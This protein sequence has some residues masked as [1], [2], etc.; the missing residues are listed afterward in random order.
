MPLEI[1]SMSTRVGDSLVRRRLAVLL[2]G[3]FALVGFL[4]SVTGVHGVVSYAVAERRREIGIRMALGA[5]PQKVVLTLLRGL[6]VVVAAGLAVGGTAFAWFS[7][8]AQSL[9]HGVST[10]DPAVFAAVLVL[11]GGAAVTAGYLPAR[12]GT[13]QSPTVVLRH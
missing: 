12:Q 1:G 13:R 7:R 4:L 2:L 8:A 9:V 11:L 3:A 6:L 10:T 5:A